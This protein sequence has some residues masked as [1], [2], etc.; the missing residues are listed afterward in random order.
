MSNVFQNSLESEPDENWTVYYAVTPDS[1][2][3]TLSEDLLKRALDGRSPSNT[4]APAVS[5]VKSWLG[6][7]LGLQVDRK[8]IDV[9]IKTMQDDYQA[10]LQIARLEQPAILKRMETPLIRTRTR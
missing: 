7:S 10:H 5:G 2:T 9:L 8:F 3:V 6:R 4:N 1:L